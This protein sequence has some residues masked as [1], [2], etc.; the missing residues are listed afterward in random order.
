[1]S[2]YEQRELLHYS[3]IQHL[4]SPSRGPW[5]PTNIGVFVWGVALSGK[6]GETRRA[7]LGDDDLLLLEPDDR[8]QVL[9]RLKA[10]Y[11][12]IW[13]Q[14]GRWCKIGD[15]EFYVN[16]LGGKVRMTSPKPVPEEFLRDPHERG[17]PCN[18]SCVLMDHFV[19]K[20]EKWAIIA[21]LA[22]VH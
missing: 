1:M 8:G 21:P 18:T 5:E 19:R 11:S 9:K 2:T 3:I 12:E 17:W 20:D 16:N 15:F 10:I 13:H 7:F 4:W 14:E 6:A 22:E